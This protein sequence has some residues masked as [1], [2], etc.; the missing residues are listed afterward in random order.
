MFIRDALS[1]LPTRPVLFLAPLIV[2]LVLSWYY[3]DLYTRCSQIRADRDSLSEAILAANPG[4]R[5]RLDEL[6][7]F[8]WDQV[9]IVTG[10]RPRGRGSECPFD[11]NWPAGERDALIAAG[12]LTVLVFARA[13]AIVRYVEMN[14]NR[15]EFP[16]LEVGLEP[17]EALFLVRERGET[18]ALRL[19][20]AGRK[21]TR[22]PAALPIGLARGTDG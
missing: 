11:W 2:V 10:Y 21:T 5:L 12:H 20:F 6:T 15:I 14:G 17:A 4:V 3:R 1:S 7:A 18:D 8:A 13:G 19:E 22:A 16:R 9:R